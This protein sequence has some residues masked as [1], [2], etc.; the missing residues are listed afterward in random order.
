MTKALC[1]ILALMVAS[2]AG[3]TNVFVS[4]SGSA[5]F[6]GSS[7][8]PC[9]MATANANVQPGDFVR[10]ADGTYST[11]PVPATSGNSVNPITYMGNP[12][13]WTAVTVPAINLNGQDYIRFRYFQSSSGNGAGMR[14][15]GT[16]TGWW[17]RGLTVRGDCLIGG[18]D[19]SSMESCQVAPP[20]VGGT[21]GHNYF[22]MGGCPLN[23]GGG[24]TFNSVVNYNNIYLRSEAGHQ[25]CFS[26]DPIFK[27]WGG[28]YTNLTWT[29]NR[30][31]V[32]FGPGSDDT[33]RGL[34]LASARYSKFQGNSW[35]FIDST[36]APSTAK[37]IWR[38]RDL[39][40]H[41]RVLGD[42]IITTAAKGPVYFSTDGGFVKCDP[43]DCPTIA[44]TGCCGRDSVGFNRYEGN[45]YKFDGAPGINFQ[46][47]MNEDTLLR[48]VI[49]RNGDQVDDNG[50]GSPLRTGSLDGSGVIESNTIATYNTSD[51]GPVDMPL[52]I[53]RIPSTTETPARHPLIELKIKNN[54]FYRSR[55]SQSGTSNGL[56]INLFNGRP[57]AV[58]YNLHSYYAG[59][60]FQVA[61]QY[62]CPGCTGLAQSAP[63]SA[64]SFYTNT[65]Q[66]FNGR[67]GSPK[68]VDSTFA[69]FDGHLGA[70][71]AAIA[72]GEGGIDMGAYT[73]GGGGG[74][75]TAPA[76]ITTLSYTGMQV[77]GSTK[78]IT[79]LWYS[80]GDDDLTGT[81]TSYDMR[82][83]TA[84]PI[85]AGNFNTAT[86]VSGMPSPSAS[87]T[88]QSK[89]VTGL[90]LNRD[91]WWAIK[92]IDEASNAGAISNVIM[93]H[94][95][96]APLSTGI[97][98]P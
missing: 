7:G 95:P 58:N 25:Y 90:Q 29:S 87:G 15:D 75:V 37:T 77:A 46:V 59:N 35:R 76:S 17:L 64:G 2:P 12:S 21:L 44:S 43:L 69:T 24:A 23:G 91:Y 52:G 73:S 92:A 81:A 98:A 1:I 82:Y 42:S 5:G 78:T 79:L 8:T 3:A 67:Y 19:A 65:S 28:A 57:Y 16:L 60:G 96:S 74:D 48:N 71:S 27:M 68:F 10:M 26:A 62:N 34:Y 45:F 84:G 20:F 83:S 94:Q 54:I 61:Y 9:S 86:P 93:T 63:G 80:V 85:N 14:L 53:W 4:P 51:V 22:V 41:N 55:T 47:G 18:F 50:G 72:N 88:L 11:A 30:V 13:N 70:G 49:L 32:V 6:P 33:K 56:R 89:Q 40:H 31:L 39:W 36:A 38:Y 66:E 97:C